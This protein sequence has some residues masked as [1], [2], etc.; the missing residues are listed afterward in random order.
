[1]SPEVTHR[2]VVGLPQGS[3]LWV[4]LTFHQCQ[5]PG[6]SAP[7]CS[8][9]YVMWPTWYGPA[10]NSKTHCLWN[11]CV[12]PLQTQNARATLIERAVL[13]ALMEPHLK[14]AGHVHTWFFG[15][16]ARMLFSECWW[17]HWRLILLVNICSQD[18][19]FSGSFMLTWCVLTCYMW[20][21]PVS[22]PQS[23][24]LHRGLGTVGFW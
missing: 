8:A 2:L 16:P 4:R 14:V 10:N 7:Q 13:H 6:V 11:Q 3:N 22:N 19:L 20:V 1:M 5:S 21:Q 17:H 18:W 23:I 12:R 9:G 15:I 24:S